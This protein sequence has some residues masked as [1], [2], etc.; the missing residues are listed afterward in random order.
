M[1]EVIADSFWQSKGLAALVAVLLGV[2]ALVRMPSPRAVEAHSR[3]G[4]EARALLDLA[5]AGNGV[6]AAW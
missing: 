2:L 6:P 1:S 3:T 4:T 5:G